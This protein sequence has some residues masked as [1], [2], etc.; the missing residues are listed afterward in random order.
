[1]VISY[2]HS[3][4]WR[5]K[6]VFYER[7]HNPKLELLLVLDNLKISRPNLSQVLLEIGCVGTPL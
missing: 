5:M 6:S 1:M 3:I 7:Q 2:I 4:C